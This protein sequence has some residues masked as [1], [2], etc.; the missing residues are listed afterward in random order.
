MVEGAEDHLL[1][2]LALMQQQGQLV[3][4]E[5]SLHFALFGMALHLASEGTA[6]R[7]LVLTQLY[8]VQSIVSLIVQLQLHQGLHSVTQQSELHLWV[9]SQH[10]VYVLK[11]FF[12][13]S[14][15]FARVLLL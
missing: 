12:R 15:H 14:Q 3:G 6:H 11:S 7:T 10:L 4:V 5:H 1:V 2:E 8:P 9:R 13:E